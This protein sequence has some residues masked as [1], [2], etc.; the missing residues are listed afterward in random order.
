MNQ[1]NLALSIRGLSKT[2]HSN[3][4]DVTALEDVNIDIASGEVVGLLGPNGSGK[5]TLVKIINS[6][7]GKD[8]GEIFINNKQISAKS[9]N[10]L[11][12]IGTIL[13]GKTGINERLSS[14]EN[15]QYYCHLMGA[16]FDKSYFQQLATTLGLTE[17]YKPVRSLSTGNK[18][19]VALIVAVIHQPQVIFMDEPTLGLDI[20]G[21]QKLQDFLRSLA[22]QG[23]T[24]FI[25]SHDL[26]FLEQITQRIVCLKYGKVLYDG[27]AAELV[28][29]EYAYVAKVSF[30]S[31]L[32]TKTL[33]TTFD[34]CGKQSSDIKFFF[35]NFPEMQS[36]LEQLEKYKEEI[37]S[38]QMSNFTLRDNYL[39]FLE[40]Q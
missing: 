15:A 32:D 22:N 34:N 25:S 27:P 29:N 33:K 9:T 23:K 1:E 20:A 36:F 18:I 8:K 30:D 37:K 2:F 38:F 39:S 16:K 26:E 3:K 12:D 5:S 4:R 21:V 17:L 6:L 24:L 35:K 40:E 7:V 19:R 14:L 11:K 10:Y 28:K 13:E 31:E